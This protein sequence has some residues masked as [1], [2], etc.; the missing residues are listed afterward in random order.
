[1][2]V[3]KTLRIWERGSATEPDRVEYFA[4]GSNMEPEGLARICPSRRLVGRAKLP[5]HR[6]A[7][8]RRSRRRLCGAA[9][10]VPCEGMTVWGALYEL[11]SPEL[12][13]LGKKEGEGWAYERA[14]VLVELGNGDGR[15]AYAH[16]VIDKEWPEIAPSADYMDE[17]LDGARACE[18]PDHYVAFLES[19]LDESKAA[20]DGEFREG[21][22]VRGTEEREEARGLPLVKV[23]PERKREGRLG[24]LA[25]VACRGKAVLARVADL[26]ER[27]PPPEDGNREFCE[28]DQSARHA[29]GMPGVETYGATVTVAPMKGKRRDM[30]VIRPRAVPLLVHPTA[31]LDSEKQ[32]AVLHPKMISLLGLVEGEWVRLY[33]VQ[34][35]DGKY[36][37]RPMS[38]RV[39]GGS[40]PTVQR[41]GKPMPYPNV[42]E[43]YLDHDGRRRLG[44]Q[45]G[46]PIMVRP[47]ILRLLASKLL[48]YGIA[49]F[50]SGAAL[51]G[52]FVL[53]GQHLGVGEVAAASL[54]LGV[55]FVLTLCL[56]VLD[57]RGRVH[58]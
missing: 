30:A 32:I 50:L 5:D 38:L 3:P 56:V 48:F 16:L 39:F 4:Y 55:A 24:S 23:R 21:L 54:A 13:E 20:S 51:I 36:Q 28:L 2:H 47:D 15:R 33:T 29:L 18:L 10:A 22:L 17:V 42:A 40:A 52:P 27:D 8:T 9:D 25:A 44:V 11:K 58:Y 14:E 49:L 45:E 34:P 41:E 1:M 7:F 26:D 6:L 31:W 35:A 46:D 37:R 12:A 57:I 53:F 19:L 43:V